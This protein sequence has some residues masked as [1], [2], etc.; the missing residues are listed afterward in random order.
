MKAYEIIL[1]EYKTRRQRNPHYSRRS[2]ARDLKL[3]PSTCSLLLRGKLGLSRSKA[4][5]IAA[6]LNFKGDEAAFFVDLVQSESARSSIVRQ[7]AAARLSQYETRFNRFEGPIG[8]LGDW[9]ILPSLEIV[10]IYGVKADEKMISQKLDISLAQARKALKTIENLKLA[11]KNYVIVS[12]GP[13]DLQIQQLHRDVLEKAIVSISGSKSERHVS[14]AVVRMR[15]SDLQWVAEEM[16]KFRRKIASKLE[17][18]EG[19]D[20]VFAIAMPIFRLDLE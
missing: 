13:T 3:S 4:A 20:S 5:F 14:T 8:S 9:F 6:M 15:K 18:G 2:F 11:S 1:Q 19:H 16:K 12:D 17:A 10:R 7:E